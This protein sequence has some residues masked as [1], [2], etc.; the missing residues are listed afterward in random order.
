MIYDAEKMGSVY[1]SWSV[2]SGEVQ[3]VLAL[4]ECN[5]VPKAFLYIFIKNNPRI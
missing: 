4:L 3:N 2:K 1:S 5:L